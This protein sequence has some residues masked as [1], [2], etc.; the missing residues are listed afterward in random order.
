M[1]FC[2]P[3]FSYKVL[4]TCV[5]MLTVNKCQVATKYLIYFLPK[6]GG[7]ASNKI[8]KNIKL[9]TVPKAWSFCE[10]SF[11][12]VTTTYQWWSVSCKCSKYP[13][14]VCFHAEG[15][16][17]LIELVCVTTLT[18]EKQESDVSCMSYI[19]PRSLMCTSSWVVLQGKSPCNLHCCC[20]LFAQFNCIWVRLQIA[21][22]QFLVADPGG[23]WD[24]LSPPILRPQII[25]W[26]PKLLFYT[27]HKKNSKTFCLASLGILFK[28]PIDKFWPKCLKM[29][30]AWHHL[31]STHEHSY[32][33]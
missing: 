11:C 12:V 8:L 21:L 17:M 18:T 29:F 15:L 20:G 6:M 25:F 28:F 9:G 23:T 2:H 5:K 19:S 13:T 1:A 26:V 10:D 14:E 27:Q 31:T 22:F 32:G 33:L 4:I 30:S 3:K 7:G 24:P 16:H